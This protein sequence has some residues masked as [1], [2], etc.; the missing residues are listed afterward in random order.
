[1]R[2]EQEAPQEAEVLYEDA[3]FFYDDS[4][5]WRER[6]VVVRA[7]YSLELHDS[8]E[9]RADSSSSPSSPSSSLLLLLLFL[10]LSLLLLLVF[11][12]LI[13]PVLFFS[14]SQTFVKGCPPRH[15][16]LPTGG[17]VLTSEETYMSMVDECFPDQR[18]E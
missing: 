18:S 17:S 13:P 7:T 3:V 1:M 9:V 15:Q 4:R 14:F 2:C 8:L 12:L 16:L 6:Y 11:L 10:H 5:R